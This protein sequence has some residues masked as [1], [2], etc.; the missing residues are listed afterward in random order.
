[1]RR[2][3]PLPLLL[4]SALALAVL[5][6][7]A[8]AAGRRPPHDLW[9]QLWPALSEVLPELVG[10]LPVVSYLQPLKEDGLVQVMKEPRN[11]LTKQYRALF[12]MPATKSA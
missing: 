2:A 1:M 11:A 12:Q 8:G 6:P 7:D 10:R 3:H 9:N 5:L 4:A